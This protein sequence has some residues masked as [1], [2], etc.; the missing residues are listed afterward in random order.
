MASPLSERAILQAHALL[1][2]QREAGGRSGFMKRRT[3]DESP[4]PSTRT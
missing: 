1:D 2:N 3:N 4:P